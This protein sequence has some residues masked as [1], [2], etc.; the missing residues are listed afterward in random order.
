M[1]TWVAWA[2]D[3]RSSGGTEE[4]VRNGLARVSAHEERV[5][6]EP[7]RHETWTSQSCGMALWERAEP[8]AFTWPAW[9]REGDRAVCTLYLP[10]GHEKVTSSSDLRQ[11]ALELADACV[12][13]PRAMLELTPPCV[14]ARVDRAADALHVLTDHLGSGR[15]FEARTPGGWV[16]SNRPLAAALFAQIAVAPDPR[17]WAHS[18]VADEFFGETTPFEGVRAVGP[19]THLEWNGRVG[20]RTVTAVDTVATTMS[21]APQLAGGDA[22]R[23]SADVAEEV[24][25]DLVAAVRSIGR[26]HESIPSVDVTGGRDSRLVAAAFA[27]ADVPFRLH[28]HDAVPADLAVAKDL[29]AQLPGSY[30]HEIDHVPSGGQLA[31]AAP[32]AVLPNAHLW[33]DYAE[34]LR[35]CMYIPSTAP[36]GIDGNLRLIIGGVGGESAHGF[37]YPSDLPQL[38]TLPPAERMRTLA[39]RV[40]TRHSPIAGPSEDAKA[41]VADHIETVLLR[42]HHLG[43]PGGTVLDHYYILE[44]MRRWGTTSERL[45]TVSPLLSLSF[46]RA[47]LALD[48]AQRKTNALHREVTRQ[49]VPQWAD[50]PYFPAEYPLDDPRRKTLAPPP[51]LFRMADAADADEIEAMLADTDVWA[52]SLDR[53]TVLDYWW[54]STAGE[55]KPAQERLLRS[56]VWRGTFDDWI[57]VTTGGELPQRTGRLVAPEP[58]PAPVAVVAPSTANQR[59]IVRRAKQ[60]T[61]WKLLRAMVPAP[62][63]RARRRARRGPGPRQ[64]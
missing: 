11:A 64:D 62:I 44:R 30:D 47:T 46:L 7:I 52:G 4:D 51:K 35:P 53:D 23:V 60:T 42:I 6:L 39:Q 2:G 43:V 10:L 9:V 37:Y 1:Q 55:T 12:R 34:A 58:E 54:K 16:W 14:V 32:L 56:A 40:V 19:A 3:P 48:P 41:L 29:L 63:L 26:F 50:I 38:L 59:S 17:G 8:R 24:A 45:G 61:A 15:V 49:L 20:R 57:T 13:D 22:N 25:A 31:K 36:R 5:R 28:T 33:H 27:A 18:A 21:V